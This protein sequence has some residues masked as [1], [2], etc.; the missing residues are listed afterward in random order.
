MLFFVFCFI[1]K[2]QIQI[3]DAG[4]YY[5]DA[6]EFISGCYGSRVAKMFV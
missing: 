2:R 4:K 1:A 5:L 6:N 3:F